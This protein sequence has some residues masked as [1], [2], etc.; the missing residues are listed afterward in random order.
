MIGLPEA[1]SLHAA[2]VDSLITWVHILMAILLVGWGAFYIY[3]LI[4]V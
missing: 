4:R 3:C 1:A 2:E